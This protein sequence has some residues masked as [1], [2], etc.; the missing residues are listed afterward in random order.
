M[1]AF[2]G[3]DSLLE[4]EF[5]RA[6]LWNAFVKRRSEYITEGELHERALSLTVAEFRGKLDEWIKSGGVG[7]AASARCPGKAPLTARSVPRVE[8]ANQYNELTDEERTDFLARQADVVAQYSWVCKCLEMPESMVNIL[9]APCAEAWTLLVSAR[10]NFETKEEFLKNGYAKLIPS[11]ASLDDQ[12]KTA[13]D[14]QQIVEAIDRL[15]N[16]RRRIEA[17]AAE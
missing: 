14:G 2:F 17:P 10:R 6:G 16:V 7:A 3:L 9:D 5:R 4:K 8:G 1:A 15:V 12:P 11:R 13:V